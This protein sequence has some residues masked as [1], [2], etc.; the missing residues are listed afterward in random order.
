MSRFFAQPTNASSFDPDSLDD[1]FRSYAFKGVS[2][3]RTGILYNVSL[4]ANYSG[5][6]L[7]FI[8]LRTREFWLHGAN[9]SYFR[10][11]P[12]N[13][14][15]PYAMRIYLVYQNLGN[16][17]GDYYKVPNY[18]FIAPVVGLM[19]YNASNSSPVRLDVGV[20][21]DPI[22]VQ[23]PWISFP[24]NK[25]VTLQCV[26]FG[27]NGSVE[28]T[29]MTLPNACIA[30]NNGHFTI[31]VPSSL[32]PSTV[33]R[34]KDRIWKLWVLGFGLG[35]LVM[36]MVALLGFLT[37]KTVKRRRI[38]KMERQ[39]ERNEALETTWIGRS[40]MPSATG[41]RTLPA[42]ENEYVP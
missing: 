18:T 17:S 11:P 19:L 7:S 40:R 23:F 42:I 16:W 14:P 41:I 24:D 25:N 36:I 31:V 6:Q 5:M 13:L 39:S 3:P 26:G 37:Y 2:R 34:K 30:R 27:T 29:E 9:L 35:I 33:K 22:L 38:G 4:P 32:P 1:T 10:I 28:L 12:H 21:R 15:V 8:R 20:N